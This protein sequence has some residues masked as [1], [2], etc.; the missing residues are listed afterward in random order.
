MTPGFSPTK[1][2]TRIAC[3][4]FLLN[5]GSLDGYVEI[6]IATTWRKSH[7]LAGIG[8]DHLGSTWTSM[9]DGRRQ[10]S[11][12]LPG[13]VWRC[14][15]SVQAGHSCRP[16][17]LG[18]HR[19]ARRIKPTVYGSNA[20]TEHMVVF[21]GRRVEHASLKIRIAILSPSARWLVSTELTHCPHR[22]TLLEPQSLVII[23]AFQ[24]LTQRH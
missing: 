11:Q 17:T 18:Q 10:L 16:A 1:C 23:G 2:R 8:V 7:A 15:G 4:G 5:I 3:A 9:R 19:T 21:L 12:A 14:R 6:V 13:L 22:T 24:G 20:M